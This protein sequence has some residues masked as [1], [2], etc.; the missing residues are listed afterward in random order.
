MVHG[1]QLQASPVPTCCAGR[2][3]SH[4]EG[5]CGPG[6][7]PVPRRQAFRALQEVSSA[8]QPAWTLQ[9]PAGCAS[10]LPHTFPQL[11]A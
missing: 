1:W 4:V 11:T 5:L 7:A 2:V 9:L 10:G 3:C 6:I 8:G